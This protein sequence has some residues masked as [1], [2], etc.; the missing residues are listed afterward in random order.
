L[1]IIACIGETE[2]EREA[3]KTNEVLERQLQAFLGKIKND[4]YNRVVIAYE[5]V[6]AI[7]TGKTASKEQAQEVHQHL[8]QF[9]EK[10]VSKDVADSL[11]IIYGG[12]V[13]AKNCEE[14]AQQNDIDGFL[15]GG[16]SLKPEFK[17]IC[18]A[19]KGKSSTK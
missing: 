17:D 16:A 2:G 9:V 7:G 13:T 4:Q 12:S 5:P 14:L 10:N 1:K 3:N 18:K 11:R 19:H 6:W 15:V 8:R